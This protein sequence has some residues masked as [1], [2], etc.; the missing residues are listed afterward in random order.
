M[1]KTGNF[2]LKRSKPNYIYS[3]TGVALVLLIMGVMGWML[4]NF[5]KV[6][7]AFKEDIR[8]SAYLRTQNKDTIAQIK[9]FI[10]TQPFAKDVQYIDKEAAK[11]LWNKDNNEDWGKIL[12]VNPLPESIDFYAKADYVNPDSLTMISTLLA[13]K[14]GNQITDL[15]YPQVLVSSISEKT[16]IFGIIFIA[17]SIVLCVIVIFSIDNTIRLAMF[18]NRFLIKTMQMVGATRSFISKPMNIRAVLNGLISAGIAIG[19]LLG[20]ITW[21][22]NLVPWLKAMRDIQLNLILFGGMIALGVGIS[23]FSTHRSVIKYL[24]MKLDD[25]Y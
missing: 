23:V 21:L 20:L 3:I 8:L 19:I 7:P 24:K 6:G 1:A 14:Y 12:D 2:S 16:K 10:T 17:F 5:S 22:E 9:E 4:L 13:S 11:A 25:L 15:Q 18:S